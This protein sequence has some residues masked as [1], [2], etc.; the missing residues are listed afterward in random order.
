MSN[1]RKQITI[2][3]A[4][5]RLDDQIL[6]MKA[7]CQSRILNDVHLVKDGEELLEYLYHRREYSEWAKAPRP[8]LILLNLYLPKLDGAEAIQVIKADSD[9]R[10]IPIVVLSSSKSEQDIRRSYELGASSY[11]TKPATFELLVE[12]I[13]TLGEYWF[14]IVELPP[15]SARQEPTAKAEDL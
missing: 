9:L 2:L 10:R 8:D 5:D 14:D 13:N 1:Q 15:A 4:E 3:L 11:L 6:I 7:L 12:A